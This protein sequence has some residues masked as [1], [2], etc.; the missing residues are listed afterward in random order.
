[1]IRILAALLSGGLFYFSLGLHPLWFAAWLAPIPILL[2]AFY[3][4][5]WRE[6]AVLS[7]IAVA[8]GISSNF[9]YYLKTTGA[10]ATP[11]LLLLQVLVWGFFILR[12]RSAVAHR[13]A[14]LLCSCI[15]LFRPA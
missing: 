1:M 11:I 13:I 2:A 9:S 6:A 7:Y 8:I 4:A 10:I 3:S 14:G 12:T 5:S 15:R